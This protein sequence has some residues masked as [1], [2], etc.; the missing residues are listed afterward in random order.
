MQYGVDAVFSGHD[1]IWERSEVAGLEI[2]PGGGEASHVIH[3]YDVGTGGDGLR[4]PESG[5]VNPYQEFLAFRDA[6]EHWEEGILLGGGTHYG[7]LE[8]T[9]QP[10][11]EGIWEA[12]MD[13]VYIFPVWNKEDSAY[14]T[15]DRR[16]YGDRVILQRTLKGAALSSP[17]ELTGALS[18][19]AY[20]NPFSESVNLALSL[21]QSTSLTAYISDPAGRI[22]RIIK[23]LTLIPGEHTLTWDG[24]TERG[25]PA[26][27]GLYILTLLTAEGHIQQIRLL[28]QD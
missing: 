21:D 16:V 13:P 20:P 1:E 3:F 22:I 5:L 23:T 28:K 17:A 11:G 10:Q 4:A 26:P 15:F 27:P 14:T 6:P 8:V 7:H 24:K 18:P 9:I 19:V 2:L 12:T 25:L